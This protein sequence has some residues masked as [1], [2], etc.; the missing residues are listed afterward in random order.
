MRN[1]YLQNL[2]QLLESTKMVH[3]TSMSGKN[4]FYSLSN[5]ST[6]KEMLFTPKEAGHLHVLYTE[7]TTGLVALKDRNAVFVC[8]H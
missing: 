8:I 6:P 1:L 7:T 2:L 5:M 4:A 3:F